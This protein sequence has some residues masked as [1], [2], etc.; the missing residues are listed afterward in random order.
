MTHFGAKMPGGLAVEAVAELVP[1][2][3][4]LVAS[5]PLAFVCRFLSQTTSITNVQIELPRPP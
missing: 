2:R 5:P 1:W 4:T 3:S